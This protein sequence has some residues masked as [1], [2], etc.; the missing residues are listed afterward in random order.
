MDEFGYRRRHR[1]LTVV[2]HD[3]RGVVWG[4]KS[5]GA[6]SLGEFF[7]DLGGQRCARIEVITTDMAAG[8]IVAI[9]E[10]TPHAQLVFDRSYVQRLVSDAVDEAR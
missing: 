5:R 9:R 4:T 7:G 10:R 2:D 3:R 1:Y 6:Q 8:Y